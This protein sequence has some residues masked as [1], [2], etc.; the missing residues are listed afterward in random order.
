MSP[1]WNSTPAGRFS[2]VPAERSSSPTTVCPDPRSAAQRLLPMKPAAPVTSARIGGA[3]EAPPPEDVADSPEEDLD[4][5]PRR[6]PVDVLQ[7]Q[8]HPLL[9]E[10]GLALDVPEADHARRHAQLSPLP[11]LEP[12][13]LVGRHGP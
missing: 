7:V 11:W 8:L 6:P 10:H 13:P 12:L 1:R 5:Q 3:S 9:E 4:V 2:R